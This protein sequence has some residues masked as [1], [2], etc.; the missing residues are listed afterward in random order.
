MVR[1]QWQM[2]TSRVPPVAEG[3]NFQGVQPTDAFA[4]V[5]ILLVSA[6]VRI[7][8]DLPTVI[9]VSYPVPFE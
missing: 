3:L 6:Y 7:L 5:Q 1:V 8:I 9:F 2:A 4:A